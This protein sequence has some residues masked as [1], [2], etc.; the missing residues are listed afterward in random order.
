[1]RTLPLLL[2][3]LAACHGSSKSTGPGNVG[4]GPAGPPP[5]ISWSGG[6]PADGGSF[7]TTGM[8]AV[9][10]D[11]SRVLIGWQMGDGGRGYPNLRLVVVDRG[12]QTLDTRIVLDAD[13]VDDT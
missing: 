7:E 4:G 8:P 1:M 3:S 6:L 2:L 10:D 9:A 11:G 5:A 13:K 12:D